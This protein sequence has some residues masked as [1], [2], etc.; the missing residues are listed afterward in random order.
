MFAAVSAH[1]LTTLSAA[2]EVILKASLSDTLGFLD[3]GEN[4]DNTLADA[5]FASD[6]VACL[7]HL[8]WLA[9]LLRRL[10]GKPL[11]DSGLRFSLRRIQER[12]KLGYAHSY[13][14]PDFLDNFLKTQ[15]AR[16]ELVTDEIVLAHL[17]SNV[18][19]GGDTTTGSMAGVVYQTLKHPRVL[20][21][22]QQELD[23]NVEETPVSWKVA[24]GLVYL[25]AVIQESL[26]FYPA[27]SFAL[28]RVVP[29]EGLKLPD[30]RFLAPGT[31]V[32]MHPWVVTRDKS[33]FG[34]DADSFVPE[35]WLQEEGE[36]TS[37]F[38][39]R[40][41]RMKNGILSFGAGKRRCA[42]KNLATLEMYKVRLLAI[43]FS[44]PKV[45]ADIAKILSTLFAKFDIELL[46]PAK[47]AQMFHAAFVRFKDFHVTLK[48][49]D[50]F[51]IPSAQVF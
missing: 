25:D 39:S 40:I 24:S 2:W 26:R 7:G 30:G 18:A 32:G 23:D 41:A 21:R 31:V 11:F 4:V 14:P 51:L 6:A 29:Q 17:I 9:G 8:P 42:G 45:I 12:H 19:A 46:A 22:L 10:S 35:R 27:V 13:T 28:E 43:T 34:T 48:P 38:S 15:K 16:P 50:K 47:E 37:A 20:K 33:I 36:A 44:L 49:R 3:R 1:S 5:L